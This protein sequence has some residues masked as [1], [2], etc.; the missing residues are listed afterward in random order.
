MVYHLPSRLERCLRVSAQLRN[1]PTSSRTGL[2][3]VLRFVTVGIEDDPDEEMVDQKKNIIKEIVQSKLRRSCY[4][5]TY[6]ESH[7]HRNPLQKWY[8][9]FCIFSPRVR[10][11]GGQ[12]VSD[13]L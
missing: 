8:C 7:L 10:F 3:R 5:V 9:Y 12:T 13:V 1:P 6:A 11:D 2:V 4:L